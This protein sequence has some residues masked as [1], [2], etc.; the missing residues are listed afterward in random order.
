MQHLVKNTANSVDICF[1]IDFPSALKA[2]GRYI[3][4]SADKRLSKLL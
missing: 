2:L 3:K 1:K 4:W